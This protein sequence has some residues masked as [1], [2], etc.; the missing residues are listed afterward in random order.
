MHGKGLLKKWNYSYEGDFSAGLKQGKGVEISDWS[1]LDALSVSRGR[2][3]YEGGF[4]ADRF[5]GEGIYT[6]RESKYNY[7]G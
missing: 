1:A 6:S 3:K 5:Q 2:Y 7:K 4:D